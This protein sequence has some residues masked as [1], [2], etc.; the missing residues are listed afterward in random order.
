MNG[1]PANGASE[2]FVG[3]FA[4]DAPL[5]ARRE[6]AYKRL[7]TM[8]PEPLRLIVQPM[9]KVAVENASE[10]EIRSLMIDVD[11][12]PAMAESGD[13]PSIIA[14]ARRYGASDEMVSMYLPLF[15]SATGKSA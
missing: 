11:A 5:D 7:M 15:E 13:Y 6:V 8:C 10:D 1:D 9:I 14:L 2:P 4:D 3:I 12:L